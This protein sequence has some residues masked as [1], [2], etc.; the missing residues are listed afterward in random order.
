MKTQRCKAASLFKP[1]YPGLGKVEAY[2]I[3]I[4]EHFDSGA[5]IE[6]Y[7]DG[8]RAVADVVAASEAARERRRVGPEAQASVDAAGDDRYSAIMGAAI[9]VEI[10]EEMDEGKTM[11][12]IGDELE[13][14]LDKLLER[15]FDKLLERSFDKASEG[16][17][18]AMSKR[19]E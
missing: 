6:R 17:V 16:I 18:A 13:E 1:E 5:S 8:S 19:D 12:Q 14:I 3:K 10:V 4:T 9:Y 2:S 15:S 11:Q 7:F